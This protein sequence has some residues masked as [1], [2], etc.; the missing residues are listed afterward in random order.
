[1]LEAGW[2]Y[3]RGQVRLYEKIARLRQ[4]MRELAQIGKQ[5]GTQPDN[6]L[7]MA[8]P[9][10]CSACRRLYTNRRNDA[11]GMSRSPQA[12]E[13]IFNYRAGIGS[14]RKQYSIRQWYGRLPSAD[15]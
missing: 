2:P 4:Q 10:L 7:S 1:M 6:Q 3:R 11:A 15:A 5:L 8:D 12:V 14:P 9:L 13:Q